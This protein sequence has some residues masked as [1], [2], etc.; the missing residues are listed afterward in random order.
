MN[1][2][3]ATAAGILSGLSSVAALVFGLLRLTA[4]PATGLLLL[5]IGVLTM[6]GGVYLVRHAGEPS[7]LSLKSPKVSALISL[8]GLGAGVFVLDAALSRPPEDERGWLKWALFG[9]AA[10]SGW[11]GVRAGWH[12]TKERRPA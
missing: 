9:V 7:A 8:L 3:I 12:A 6:E 1:R 5:A 4:S 10:L 11:I 2:R